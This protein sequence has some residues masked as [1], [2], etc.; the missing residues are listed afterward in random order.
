MRRGVAGAGERRSVRRLAWLA[1]ALVLSLTLMPG[2][3]APSAL[4]DPHHHGSHHHDPAHHDPAHHDSAL[5]DAGAGHSAHHPADKAPKG[6]AGHQGCPF[7]T[8]HPGYSPPPPQMAA[9]QLPAAFTLAVGPAVLD[10]AVEA[11]QFL[12]SLRPRAPPAAP[13]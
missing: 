9:L 10:I 6:C 4:A 1:V 11:P 12:T 2:Y 3:R 7:C 5:A 8:V 13:V